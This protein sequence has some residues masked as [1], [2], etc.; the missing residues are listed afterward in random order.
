MQTVMLWC[1]CCRQ[2]LPDNNFYRDVKCG[3]HAD[4]VCYGCIS[5]AGMTACPACQ[6]TYS[7]NEREM[8]QIYISSLT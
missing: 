6:R 8:L 1:P 7:G 5:R 3:D 4:P 2:Q